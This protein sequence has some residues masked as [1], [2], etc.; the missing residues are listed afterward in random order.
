[1][2][3]FGRQGRGQGPVFVT[4][5]RHTEPRLLEGGQPIHRLGQQAQ[6]HLALASDLR[7]TKRARFAREVHAAL[8]APTPIRTPSTRLTHG[9][10]LSHGPIVNAYDPTIAPRLKGKRHGPA[11]FGRKPGMASEPAT[12]FILANRVPEGTPSDLSAVLPVLDK[13]QSALDRVKVPRRLQVDSVAGARGGK[14]TALRQ[15]LHTR[16]LLTIGIPTTVAPIN[17]TPTA[18]EILALRNEAGLNR[19]R[20]PHHVQWAWACGDRRPVVDSHSASRLARGAGQGR[21]TGLQG[22]VGP[23]G[24]TVMAH[25]GA[26]LVRIRQ[27]R[28]SNRAQKFRRLLGLTHGQINE[29]NSPQN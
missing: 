26:T 27:Q 1:M 4:L 8:G 11:P 21:D 25:H 7:H 5:V 13:V 3:R 29:I 23:P 12:G 19:Q 16:G 2:R 15:A 6:Q 10:K 9:K 18:E 22:A 28:R 17:P 24:M 20:P 14:D